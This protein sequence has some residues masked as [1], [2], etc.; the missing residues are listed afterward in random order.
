ML[1]ILRGVA[2]SVP[3]SF[4]GYTLA[5][6]FTLEQAGGPVWDDVV[7]EDDDNRRSYRLFVISSVHQFFSGG[8]LHLI[9]LYW[10]FY[11]SPRQISLLLILDLE[12]VFP[13]FFT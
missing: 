1:S 12:D 6:V 10:M 4:P 9:L 8:F 11:P 3:E 5:E 2:V 7:V 13:M